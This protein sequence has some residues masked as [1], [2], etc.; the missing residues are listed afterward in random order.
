MGLAPTGKAPPC[1]GARGLRT[2]VDAAI[3]GQG[4]A[5]KRPRT[6][7]AVSQLSL[8]KLRNYR[9]PCPFGLAAARIE[10]T[11]G[12]AVNHVD[13][14]FGERDGLIRFGDAQVRSS[15]V[16]KN[17]YVRRIRLWSGRPTGWATASGRRCYRKASNLN[18]CRVSPV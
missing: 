7:V 14:R 11:R 9:D 10:A 18:S 3:N 5:S 13:K 2:F 15:K 6:R 16:A 1:H 17:R 8:E 4:V 12:A